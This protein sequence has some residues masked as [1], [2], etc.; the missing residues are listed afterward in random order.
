M[1]LTEIKNEGVSL[2]RLPQDRGQWRSLMNKVMN[3]GVPK[4]R[5]NSRL[6]K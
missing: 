4:K 1:D 6:V 5:G 3:L 2:I